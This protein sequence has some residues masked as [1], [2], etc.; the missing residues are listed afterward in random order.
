MAAPIDRT[1]ADTPADIFKTL[2]LSVI[3]LVGLLAFAAV[4][5]FHPGWI[6]PVALLLT[7]LALAAVV[8]T[9]RM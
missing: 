3:G 9:T 2:G 4:I 7:A 6:V 8:G 5:L 1:G